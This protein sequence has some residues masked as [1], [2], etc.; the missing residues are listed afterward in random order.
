MN[1][2]KEL[3]ELV[4]AGGYNNGFIEFSR[5]RPVGSKLPDTDTRRINLMTTTS[6]SQ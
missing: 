4:K 6:N 2:Q 3:T 1:L 5:L